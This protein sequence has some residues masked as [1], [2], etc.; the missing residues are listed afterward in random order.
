MPAETLYVVV[1]A[2]NESEN[3]AE[4]VEG[5]YP[6]VEAHA[7]DGSS[8]LLV[9]D[10]G[11]SDDTYARLCELAR[12]RPLLEPL[13]KPNAG[14]G[15]TLIF[16][17]NHAIAAGAAWIFQTD[18]DGQTLPEEFEGFWELRDGYDAIF[19]KRTR[20]Q[21]GRGRAFV[22]RTLCLLLRLAFGVK[23]PDANA[24]FRL[25][26]ASMVARYLPKLPADFN[27]PNAMLVAY[28]AHFGE[29]VCFREV[30]FRPRQGGTNSINVRKIVRIGLKA[31]GDFARLRRHLND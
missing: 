30:T 13:T 9:V 21:D 20:R 22:E 29:R 31:V 7:A 25:M 8:R 2:Y 4:L 12:D 24:P 16:G 26:R 27:L 10:D 28:A 14:H 18:S 19:G 17:Y 1:P 23:V 6:V 3:I 15:P 5:W 11:S